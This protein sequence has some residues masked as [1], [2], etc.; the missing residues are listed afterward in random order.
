MLKKLIF[1]KDENDKC[2]NNLT[3][4]NVPKT[5]LYPLQKFVKK[6]LKKYL[7]PFIPHF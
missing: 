2:F 3:R 7:N 6:S 4:L 1:I 5:E